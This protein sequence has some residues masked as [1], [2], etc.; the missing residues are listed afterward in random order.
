[1]FD[2]EVDSPVLSQPVIVANTIIAKIIIVI[3]FIFIPCGL[4]GWMNREVYLVA[5]VQQHQAEEVA[6]LT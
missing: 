6:V 4:R 2:G 1:V 5:R 3:D